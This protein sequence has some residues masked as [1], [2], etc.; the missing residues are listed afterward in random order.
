MSLEAAVMCSCLRDGQAR[1]HP[2]PDLLILDETGY[3][4]LRDWERRTAAEKA[5]HRE[6]ERN[7]CRHRDGFLVDERLGDGTFVRRVR[8]M[9]A[10][11][12]RPEPAGEVFP[13]LLEGVVERSAQAGELLPPQHAERLIREV[14][15]ARERKS[16][17]SLLRERDERFLQRFLEAVARLA[18]ASMSTGNPIVF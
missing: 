15:I 3:P 8:A 2:H 18:E 13:A 16:R 7:R 1:P 11:L 17:L 12:A 14:E 6:W 9:L 10:D 4:D 5:A